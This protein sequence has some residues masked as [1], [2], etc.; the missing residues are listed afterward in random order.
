M[1]PYEQRRGGSGTGHYCHDSIMRGG[2]DDGATPVRIALRTTMRR[3]RRCGLANISE[4][5]EAQDEG[6]EYIPPISSLHN[7]LCCLCE[8]LGGTLETLMYVELLLKKKL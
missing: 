1:M 3:Q 5:P 2:S 4:Q 8:G 7:M 6:K